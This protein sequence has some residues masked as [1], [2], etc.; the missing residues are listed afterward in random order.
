MKVILCADTE[1]NPPNYVMGW[2]KT[3]SDYSKEQAI[4]KWSW[5]DYF[6]N[7]IKVIDR[8]NAKI[9]WALRVDNGPVRQQYLEKVFPLLEKKGVSKDDAG[10]HIH[11]WSY[12]KRLGWIQEIKPESEEE[13]VNASLNYW[14][15]YF[16]EKARISRMGWCTGSNA[17][18]DAL[19]KH[20]I[21]VDISALPGLK[22]NGK[23]HTNIYDWTGSLHKPFYISETNYKLEGSRNILEIPVTVE[24]SGSFLRNGLNVLYP[25]AKFCKNILPRKVINK[26]ASIVNKFFYISPY[27]NN[28]NIIN[29]NL[30][31]E[32][33]VGYFHPSDI[34][35][36]NTNKLNKSFLHNLSLVL[37]NL[38][39]L[40]AEFLST[41]DILRLK[42]D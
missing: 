7:L 2:K 32:L 15:S 26:T 38:K 12:N 21:N 16:G 29:K 3:G 27:Q 40:N 39:N 13:I 33:L 24:T 9:F 22:S 37:Q 14:K 6:D 42:N 5:L 25:L 28:M 20:G 11:T 34:L 36:P 18:V 1:D 41:K 10:I 19:E 4:I 23:N 17:I 8:F 35:D 30:D 31:N